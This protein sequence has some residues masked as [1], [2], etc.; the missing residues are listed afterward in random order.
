MDIRNIFLEAPHFS[1]KCDGIKFDG[2]EPETARGI[3]KAPSSDDGETVYEITY[4]FQNGIK[5]R[6]E[7]RLYAGFEAARV[8]LHFEN[9]SGENSGQLSEICDCDISLPFNENYAAPAVG[10]RLTPDNKA[11]V[12]KSV[13]S[14]WA[15]DEFFEYPDFIAPGQSRLYSCEHGRSSQGLMPYFDLNENDKGAL[16]AI[17]WTGQWN[18]RFAGEDK[19]IN[20]KTGIEGLDFYLEPHENIRTS[21][22]VVMLYENGRDEA[23]VAWRRFVKKHI[24]NLAKGERPK[25]GPLSLMAWGAISSAK[26]IE[27]IE[28]TTSYGIGAEYYWI[29]AGWY[30]YSTGPCPSEHNGDWGAHTGSWVVNKTY[31]PDGLLEVAK[32]VKENGLKFL[33]WIEPE[34]VIRGTD[35]PNEH[36][37]WF[38]ELSP[39]DNTL[40]LDLS[41][42]EAV[43]GTYALIAGYVEKFGIKCYRQDFNTNP[44]AYWRKYDG[45][46]R[47]GLKEIKYITGLYKFWDMLLARFPDL[48]I[49]NCASGGRRNDIE[50]MSRSVPLWRS[51][52]QCTW[53]YEPEVAQIHTTGISRWLPYHGTGLGRYAED[54][55]KM[56]SAYAPALAAIFWGYEDQD[57]I[58]GDPKNVI[59]KKYLAEYRSIR[60]YLS[61][62]YYPLVKNSTCDTSWCAWQYNRPEG[63]DGIILA[64]R[65]PESPMAKA[66][67]APKGLDSAGTY[68]FVDADSGEV[69]V[70]G[71]KEIKDKG[72]EVAIDEKRSS[73]L[74]RYEKM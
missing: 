27:R 68:R 73:R 10:H 63:G 70:L 3:E 4:D 38:L 58:D 57:F 67:F 50:M 44:L 65:R 33:I 17:G 21:S 56:R 39:Q 66:V 49:D 47:R 31:H 24:A 40:L 59:A 43:L 69:R 6:E 71:A 52:Y 32:A 19:K 13:G 48:I 61:C 26:M 62:D 51:D 28:K 2:F 11:R 45:E 12:F 42:P 18:I 5:V 7:L 23:C 22:A 55:Y 64:F 41:N 9:A 53:D 29:D 74:I 14:N 72:F 35:T 1:F 36:P 54:A 34:R 16:V 25:E 60:K 37:D 20:I 30:G 15:R 46:G 8:L